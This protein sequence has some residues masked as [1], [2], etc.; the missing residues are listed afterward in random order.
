MSTHARI[1]VSARGLGR[2]FGRIDAL[3]EVGFEIPE[4]T[5]AGILGRNGAGKTTL[6]SLITG[7]DRPSS[8]EVAVFGHRPFEHSA[9]LSAMSFIRDNQRYPDDYR[10]H[11]ALRAA[12]IFHEGWDQELADSLVERFRLPAKP[13][14]KKFS[15]GQLSAVGIVIGLASRARLTLFDEPYLGLDATA[16]QSFYDALLADYSAHPRTILVSTHLID[17]MEPLLERVLVIDGGRLV[18]DAEAD[19]AKAGFHQLSGVAA[20][21]D[22]VLGGREALRRHAVGG[23]ATVLVRGPLDAPAQRA[24]EQAGIEAAPASLQQVVAALGA[25]DTDAP[26][27]A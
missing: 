11:H 18:L 22:R 23:L 16:R 9:T 3:Q 10:L 17:E 1:A 27:A 7:Q 20:A 12:R 13:V 19:L 6:M 24:A 26:A 4:H 25:A 8:G 2:R 14:I 15:R 5:I 21:V